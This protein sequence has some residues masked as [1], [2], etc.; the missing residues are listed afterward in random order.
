MPGIV[1][2]EPRRPPLQGRAHY[3]A[4]KNPQ[5]IWIRSAPYFSF[6]ATEV[7]EIHD[8]KCLNKL[9]LLHHLTTVCLLFL[10]LKTKHFL[11]VAPSFLFILQNKTN[12][13][14]L[15]RTHFSR[16]CRPRQ[17]GPFLDLCTTALYIFVP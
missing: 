9:F 2:A 16:V 4:S 1:Q 3:R 13:S 12:C 15:T 6:S 5:S 11:S 8:K 14:S 7:R 10:H 17:P